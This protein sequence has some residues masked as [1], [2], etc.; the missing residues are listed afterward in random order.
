M[1]EVHPQA[2]PGVWWTI[3]WDARI[4]QNRPSRIIL[5]SIFRGDWSTEKDEAIWRKWAWLWV[6][7]KC[8][9]DFWK[10]WQRWKRI[11][12]PQR[13]WISNDRNGKQLKLKRASETYLGT[14]CWWQWQDRVLRIRFSYCQWARIERKRRAIL[15]LGWWSELNERL[16]NP[17]ARCVC[18]KREPGQKVIKSS[19]HLIHNFLRERKRL[20]LEHRN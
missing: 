18:G 6:G 12:W 19:H 1:G 7:L 13:I 11:Y 3:F 14:W 20:L 15:R 17:S 2:A 8:Q 16:E 4:L 9:D 10:S 5:A